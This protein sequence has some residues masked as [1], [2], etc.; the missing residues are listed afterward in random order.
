VRGRAFG[1]QAVEG[2]LIDAGVASQTRTL[3]AMGA[4]MASG[5]RAGLAELAHL[6]ADPA[7]ER[8]I[9][10]DG[11]SSRGMLWLLAGDPGRAISDLAGSLGLARRG[12]TLTLGVRAYFWLAV[13]P[14]TGG[15]WD[16]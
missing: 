12:A 13:A 2:G 7:Q 4:S 16:A 6:D 14:Y 15:P 8:A 11:L 9:D 5:P 3:I 1:R 10:V